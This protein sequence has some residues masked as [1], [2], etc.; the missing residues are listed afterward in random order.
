MCQLKGGYSLPLE[1]IFWTQFPPVNAAELVCVICCWIVARLEHLPSW[2]DHGTWGNEQRWAEHKTGSRSQH[3]TVIT[4]T[5]TQGEVSPWTLVR[6]AL[7]TLS[8]QTLQDCSDCRYRALTEMAATQ[9]HCSDLESGC[10]YS[11]LL[12]NLHFSEN[13]VL[14]LH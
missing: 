10:F 7:Q 1:W 5:S 4:C 9:D 12:Q 11:D 2:C 14:F 13:H 6:T 3:S 8:L